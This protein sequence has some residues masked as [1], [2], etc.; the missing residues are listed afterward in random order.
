MG[1]D[2]LWKNFISG[3]SAHCLTW[4]IFIPID[5]VKTNIQKSKV[6]LT[7]SEV[8]ISEYSK[9]GIKIF[10]KGLLPVTLRTIPEI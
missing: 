2:K 3:A 4:V 7:I 8:I 5:F 10:W 1:D 6:K 9:G